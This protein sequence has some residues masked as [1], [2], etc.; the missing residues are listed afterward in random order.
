M[1]CAPAATVSAGLAF[2][3]RWWAERG[4]WWSAGGL[5]HGV[6]FVKLVLLIVVC[7][8]VVLCLFTRRRCAAGRPS[9]GAPFARI[10][11]PSGA[12][13]K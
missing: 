7:C 3:R 8:C 12:C 1:R 4:G 2:A 5:P 13:R 10:V 11:A 6:T 9:G